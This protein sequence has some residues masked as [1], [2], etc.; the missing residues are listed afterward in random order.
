MISLLSDPTLALEIL[1]SFCLMLAEKSFE[2]GECLGDIAEKELKDQLEVMKVSRR[3]KMFS[4]TFA[5]GETV[6]SYSLP[7]SECQAISRMI[8]QVIC[9]GGGE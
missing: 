9:R 6:V 7:Y 8:I 5:G 3:L 1:I 2:A 4:I